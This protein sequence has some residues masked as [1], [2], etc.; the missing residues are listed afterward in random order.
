MPP[1]REVRWTPG[2][3][4][5]LLGGGVLLAWLAGEIAV[6]RSV[7]ALQLGYLAIAVA[8]LAVAL[9][10]RPRRVAASLQ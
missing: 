9:H 4:G 8:M 6:L 1:V 7:H 10:R 5:L 3:L 2:A